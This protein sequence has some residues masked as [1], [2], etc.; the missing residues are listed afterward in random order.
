ML[1]QIT[2]LLCPHLLHHPQ[3]RRLPHQLGI[4]GL[5]SAQFLPDMVE[6]CSFVKTPI[7]VAHASSCAWNNLP[8]LIPMVT[9]RENPSI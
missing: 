7:S 8:H 5:T 2:S 4:S 3:N 1:D 9:R 6:T